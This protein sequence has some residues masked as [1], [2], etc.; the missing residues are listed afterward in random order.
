MKRKYIHLM[1]LPVLLLFMATGCVPTRA[2]E[3]LEGGGI[4]ILKTDTSGNPL[5]NAG[6]RFCREATRAE[7]ND[8][9]VEKTLLRC[10]GSYITAVYV[11]FVVDGESCTEAFTGTDGMI[12]VR[13][14]PYGSYYLVESRTPEGYQRMKE[15]VRVRIHK[16]SHLI[17]EDDFRDDSGILIDNTLHI[18]SLRDTL[19]HTGEMKG[20][21]VVTAVV[22]ALFSSLSLMLILIRKFL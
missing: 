12:Q 19:P 14:L 10:D 11:T 8:S 1:V 22:A 6:F 17:R 4:T 16:Y 3:L 7:E 18:I 2:A 15:P 9:S 5:E 20:V 13:G 21:M